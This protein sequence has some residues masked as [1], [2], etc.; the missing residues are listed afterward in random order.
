MLS[1]SR[2]WGHSFGVL[3]ALSLCS[4]GWGCCVGAAVVVWCFSAVG[5]VVQV[6]VCK[7]GGLGGWVLST[8]ALCGVL[9]G[10]LVVIVALVGVLVWGKL[11]VC[12][13]PKFPGFTP[14]RG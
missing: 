11:L 4:M 1:V 7:E 8:S 9:V 3:V 12:P 10:G 5:Q 13:N 2:F 6:V 14:L